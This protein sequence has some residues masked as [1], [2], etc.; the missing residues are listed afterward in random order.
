MENIKNVVSDVERGFYGSVNISFDNVTIDGPAD[1]ESAFKE[2]KNIE[3]INSNLN[4]R[5]P[6]W[7]DINVK[8]INCKMGPTCRAAFWYDEGLT[9]NKCFS[10]GV[11]AVRECKFV[12]IID[13]EFDSEEFGWKSSNINV[14]NSKITAVYAFF[15]SK[16]VS[17]ENVKF[18]G[19]Y[20]FQYIENLQISHCE[21][22]TKDAFWHCKNVVVKDSIIKGEY[23]GWYSEN[24]TFINCKIIG[25]QPLCYVKGLRLVNCKFEDADFAFEYSEVSGNI[26]GS[27]ISIKN[28]LSGVIKIDKIPEMIIDKNDKS[29]GRFNIIEAKKS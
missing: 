20:S 5:Y 13:S 1:G 12:D 2:C 28:P 19:K 25:T 6:C 24:I 11:K 3:I 21:L 15:D 23:L 17:L 9:L 26:I 4:L 10:S 7:H 27:M 29:M 14:K 18:K 16:I 22:D 8:L